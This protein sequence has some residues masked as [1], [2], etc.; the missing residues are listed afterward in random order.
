M[1]RSGDSHKGSLVAWWDVVERQLYR[2]TTS[3]RNIIRRCF[4]ITSLVI[5]IQLYRGLILFDTPPLY[6]ALLGTFVG[7][8]VKPLIFLLVYF[9]AWHGNQTAAIKIV[10]TNKDN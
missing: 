2:L 5:W 9:A 4:K 8:F 1:V 6:W 10:K 3:D 7:R